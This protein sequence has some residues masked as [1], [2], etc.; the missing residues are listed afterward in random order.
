MLA[1]LY[2]RTSKPDSF[3]HNSEVTAVRGYGS[4]KNAEGE[5]EGEAKNSSS[6]SRARAQSR[7]G[8]NP[9]IL[10]FSDSWELLLPSGLP[11]VHL[12]CTQRKQSEEHRRELRGRRRSE[13]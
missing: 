3:L 13:R 1:A 12:L 8:K 2:P 6:S 5:K 4:P 11:A 9:V 10:L 7:V